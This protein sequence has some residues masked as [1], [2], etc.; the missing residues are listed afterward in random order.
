[1]EPALGSLKTFTP[2]F[3]AKQ[4]QNQNAAN[5]RKLRN[6][7]TPAERFVMPGQQQLQAKMQG[8]QQ[9]QAQRAAQAAYQQTFADLQKQGIARPARPARPQASSSGV[10][11]F[12]E[13][14]GP[15]LK[16]VNDQLAAGGPQMLPQT[17]AL[18]QQI[19]GQMQAAK[20]QA[21][22]DMAGATAIPMGQQPVL[23]AQAPAPAAPAAVAP[24]APA[25]PAPSLPQQVAQQLAAPVAAPAAPGLQ[26]QVA[27]QVGA[28]PVA[29]QPQQVAQQPAQPAAQPQQPGAPSAVGS[30]LQQR[31]L[32]QLTQLTEAPSAYGTEQIQQMREAQRADLEAQFGAQRSQLEEELARRGLSASS[33]AAGQFGDIAGQQARALATMEAG[34]TE[35]AAEAMQRG[36]EAAIQ[37]LTQAAGI[38]LEAK[39]VDLQS[40]KVQA[41]IEAETKRLMQADRSLDLTQ[42]R[43]QAQER[44]AYA[45]LAEQAASRVSRDKLTIAQ[46][47]QQES[48]FARTLGLDEQRFKQD[49]ADKARDFQLREKTLDAT[50]AHNMAMVDLQQKQIDQSAYQFAKNYNLDLNKFESDEKYRKMVIETMLAQYAQPPA[51]N[52]LPG[53][54]GSGGFSGGGGGAG[55][56]YNPVENF[57]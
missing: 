42:A 39:G 33:I 19:S 2:A 37:G 31:L 15:L 22:A 53:Y 6:P 17:Q 32:Q 43:D 41:D 4:K 35:K 3:D 25:A 52:P 38:E 9:A 21:D 55:Y 36:R 57:E 14:G 44:I 24:A 8:Q 49:V 13:S 56:P 5:D 30:D 20:Q 45:Q 18:S 48:Q 51:S 46:M 10:I 26:Q 47:N 23:T 34:L 16:K 29:A 27:Q 40:K 11:K 12:E 50:T 1:M 7:N 28:Q 54:G